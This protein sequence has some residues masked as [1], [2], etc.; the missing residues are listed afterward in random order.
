MRVLIHDQ[1]YVISQNFARN[2]SGIGSGQTVSVRQNWYASRINDHLFWGETVAMDLTTSLDM[3]V[4][5]KNELKKFT[6]N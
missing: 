4:S 6:V 1:D 2:C 3:S 5:G